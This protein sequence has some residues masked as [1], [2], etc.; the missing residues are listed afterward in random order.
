MR[1]A[2]AGWLHSA[3]VRDSLV[4]RTDTPPQRTSDAECHHPHGV[5]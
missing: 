1:R 3:L 2:T 5:R 4:G